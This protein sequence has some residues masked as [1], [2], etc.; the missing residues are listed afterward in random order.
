MTLSG[1]KG[2]SRAAEMLNNQLKKMRSNDIRKFVTSLP[3]VQF[4]RVKDLTMEVQSNLDTLYRAMA[5][6]GNRA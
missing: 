5:Y 1:L 3:P 2:Y 6:G 4:Q